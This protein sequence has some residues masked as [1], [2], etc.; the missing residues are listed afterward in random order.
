MQVRGGWPATVLSSAASPPVGPSRTPSPRRGESRQLGTDAASTRL[1][2]AK[3]EDTLSKIKQLSEEVNQ[4]FPQLQVELEKLGLERRKRPSAE[5][6]TALN[7]VNAL[8]GSS[9]ALHQAAERSSLAVAKNLAKSLTAEEEGGKSVGTESLDKGVS[10]ETVDPPTSNP[11]VDWD[12]D[13]A[14]LL[15]PSTEPEKPYIPLSKYNIPPKILEVKMAL[16][17]ENENKMWNHTHYVNSKGEKVEV[18]YC[19]TLEDCEKVLPR[20]LDEEVVGFD[21]EWIFPE[22]SKTSIR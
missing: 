8:A 3:Q 13:F 11:R 21:L 16:D 4:F 22:R 20:F 7:L 17:D 1:A 14:K 9:I 12:Q 19:K 15:S 6:H 2:K 5:L 10:E 18:H